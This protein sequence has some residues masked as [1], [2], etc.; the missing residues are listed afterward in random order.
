[1]KTIRNI[2]AQPANPGFRLR[3]LDFALAGLF[4]GMP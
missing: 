4:L 1:M 3:F 2:I